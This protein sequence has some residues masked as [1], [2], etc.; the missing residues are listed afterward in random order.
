ML[1]GTPGVFRVY[2]GTFGFPEAAEKAAKEIGFNAFKGEND[3]RVYTGMFTSLE[4][5]EEAR[6]LLLL[7]NMATT[8]KSNY[9]A[10]VHNKKPW[11]R[12]MCVQGFFFIHHLAAV[13]L[14]AQLLMRAAPSNSEVSQEKDSI[15]FIKIDHITSER[16]HV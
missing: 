4:S 13:P 11:N 2:I 16:L 3:T 12:C 1:V 14:K 15:Q 10:R 6:G 5:A 8:Q 9:I 7:L